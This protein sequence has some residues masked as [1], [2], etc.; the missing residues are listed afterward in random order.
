MDDSFYDNCKKVSF[1]YYSDVLEENIVETMWA[2]VIDE[3]EALYRLVNIPFY[4]A[5]IAPDDIFSVEIGHDG[6]TLFYQDTIESSGNSVIQIAVVD[7]QTNV[8]D[9]RNE[10]VKLHCDSEGVTD[11]FFV[12]EVKYDND[13]KIINQYL[14]KL[15]NEGTID[16][17]EPCLSS[18]HAAD[19]N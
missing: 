7:N 8:E 19:L 9:L 1:N 18:K 3:Q 12:I 4:G 13:Y 5:L 15:Q 10:F 14:E 17:A 6:E 2:E 16:Y 11:T